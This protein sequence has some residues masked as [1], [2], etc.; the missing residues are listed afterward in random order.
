VNKDHEQEE[1]A[2]FYEGVTQSKEALLEQ[3]EQ[4]GFHEIGPTLVPPHIM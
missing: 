1:R 4:G 2:L 3:G